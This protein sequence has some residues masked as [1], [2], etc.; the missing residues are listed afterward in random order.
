MMKVLVIT[1]LFPNRKQPFLGIFVRERIKAVAKLCNVKVVA[2]VPW[3]P[4]LKIFKRW[5]KFSQ[6]PKKEIQGGLEVYHPR[7]FVIPKIGKC[8]DGIFYF[9]SIFPYILK[10]RKKFNFDILD[11]HWAYPDG[12]AGVLIGKLLKRPVSISVRGTDITIYVGYSLLRKIIT[13]LLNKANV[14]IAVANSLKGE[15]VKLGIS[16]ER[17]NVIPNGIDTKKFLPL[18]RNEARKKLGLPV[19]KFIILSVGN[20]VELKGFH[21]LVDAVFKI[22]RSKKDIL[23]LI[24]GEGEWRRRLEMQI[25][26]LNADA[27]IKLL[28]LKSNNELYKWYNAA[29]IFCLASEK[30][31]CPNVILESLACG[32]PVVATHVGGIPEIICSEDYGILVKHQNSEELAKAIERALEKNWDRKML[33]QYAQKNSWDKC[34][35]KVFQEFK[36]VLSL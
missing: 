18:N 4:P 5:Y 1:Q 26:K 8:F 7:F 27:C 20:L 36:T 17:I 2:P 12:F 10:L 25:A 31:G 21:Y 30:E 3:F 15:I 6:I 35:N 13:Y 34:A 19:E 33:V 28:G 22:K 24:I 9:L 32:I 11:V 14:I 23:L 16:E 29:N